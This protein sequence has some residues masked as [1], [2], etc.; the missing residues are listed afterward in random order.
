MSVRL[1]VYAAG[2]VVS[3]TGKTKKHWSRFKLF[4]SIFRKLE[5][6]AIEIENSGNH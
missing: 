3:S 5:E 4:A 2:H 1:N 6:I